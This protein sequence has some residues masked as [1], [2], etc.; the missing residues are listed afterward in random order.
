MMQNLHQPL[1][2]QKTFQSPR[3]DLLILLSFFPFQSFFRFQSFFHFLSLSSH[4]YWKRPFSHW[5]SSF[6]SMLFQFGQMLADIL[7]PRFL[8]CPKAPPMFPSSPEDQA[9]PFPL[10]PLHLPQLLLHHLLLLQRVIS[11]FSGQ[12]LLL[13]LHLLADHHH[14]LLLQLLFQVFQVCSSVLLSIPGIPL[15]PSQ[16]Y[17]D[18]LSRES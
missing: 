1:I 4:L 16:S 2:P 8:L 12:V 11:S 10:L 13:L 14:H 17:P 18:Q 6:L 5:P 9:L 3:I 7:L 15:I